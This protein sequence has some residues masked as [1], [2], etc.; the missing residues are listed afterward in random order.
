VKLKFCCIEISIGFL[1][2][3]GTKK[4]RNFIYK[5]STI[6]ADGDG[7]KLSDQNKLNG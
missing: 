3:D 5:C 7:V 6:F 2:A 1:F 4:A